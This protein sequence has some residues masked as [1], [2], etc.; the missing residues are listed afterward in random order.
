MARRKLIAYIDAQVW[1]ATQRRA[2]V[3]DRS[4]T[5]VVRKALRIYLEGTGDLST[6]GNDD[7]RT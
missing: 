4:A 3:E 2:K 1:E 6:G 5:S 7:D